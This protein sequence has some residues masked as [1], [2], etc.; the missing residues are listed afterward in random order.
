MTFEPILLTDRAKLFRSLSYDIRVLNQR[1]IATEEDRRLWDIEAQ[2]LREK[3]SSTYREISCDLPH[4]FEHYLCDC[5]IRAKDAG[6]RERQEEFVARLLAF[7]S[8]EIKKGRIDAK[9]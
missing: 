9:A 5:D 4:E 2:H 6:Y 1:P 7:V 3:L 8:A